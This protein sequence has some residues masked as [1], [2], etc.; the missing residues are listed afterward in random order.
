MKTFDYIIVIKKKSNK[1][2]NRISQLML[3]LSI[4]AF[5]GTAV[6]SPGKNIPTIILSLLI[7][8]WWYFCFNQIKRGIEPS[9][10]LALLLAAVGWYFQKDG[11]WIS[12]IY[13]LAAALEKQVKFQEEIAFDDAEIVINSFPKKKY[14]WNDLKNVV[15]KDGLLT[16]DFN[17]NVLIQKE[18]DS[19]VPPSVAQEFNAFAQQNLTNKHQSK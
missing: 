10:R 8:A 13:L 1:R 7:L 17:N 14:A 3:L 11:I 15:L 19:E 18:V 4:L 2:I 12:I 6:I 9:F 5:I 16:L